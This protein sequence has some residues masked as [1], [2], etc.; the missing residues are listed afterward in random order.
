MSLAPTPIT[1]DQAAS[2]SRISTTDVPMKPITTIPVTSYAHCLQGGLR[3]AAADYPFDT[4][5]SFIGS[6]ASNVAKPS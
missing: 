2:V 1:G 4:S 6:N 3:V 5:L